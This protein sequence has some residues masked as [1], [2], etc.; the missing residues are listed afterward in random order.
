MTLVGG[1]YTGGRNFL[2]NLLNEKH[3]CRPDQT[4]QRQESGE[5]ERQIDRDRERER[6]REHTKQ[7]LASHSPL[8]LEQII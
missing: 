2:W 7:W 8:H 5:R 4:K 3:A 1:W 6:Q